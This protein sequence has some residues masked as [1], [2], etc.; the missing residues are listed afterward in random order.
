MGLARPTNLAAGAGCRN[1]DIAGVPSGHGRCAAGSRCLPA[2]AAGSNQTPLLSDFLAVGL[3]FLMVA[4]HTVDVGLLLV[5][6]MEV[7]AVAKHVNVMLVDDLDGSAAQET[8]SFGLDGRQYDVDLSAAHAAQLRDALAAFVAVARRGEGRVRR[9]PATVD[10]ARS[11]VDRERTAAVRE[12]A[13]AHGHEV[14]D[15]G[16][17]S[18]TVMQA[19]DN[20]EAPP[21]AAEAAPAK[22]KRKR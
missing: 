18:K 13:R 11:D 8:V 16:R 2:G 17:I 22:K 15:R 9:R 20:R 7:V 19:Y 4:S 10:G 1:S 6:G 21:P 12:W 3:Q 5:D 14:S